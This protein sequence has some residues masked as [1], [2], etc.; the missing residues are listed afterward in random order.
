MRYSVISQSLYDYPEVEYNLQYK[1]AHRAE[2]LVYEPPSLASYI[3]K[4]RTLCY[5]LSRPGRDNNSINS[6]S[7]PTNCPPY[8][9]GVLPSIKLSLVLTATKDNF[10]SF[11]FFLPLLFE[12][13]KQVINARRLL[14]CREVSK[15]ELVY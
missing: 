8:T 15:L 2:I 7:K 10:R 3:N 12:T 6:L 4:I 1:S 11:S 13:D 14:F 9:S 5:Q